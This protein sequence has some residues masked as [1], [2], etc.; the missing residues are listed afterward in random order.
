MIRLSQVLEI[1]ARYA[2][3]PRA[4]PDCIG[5]GYLCEHNSVYR[6]VRE[7]C[8]DLG[9]R[10]TA[11][12]TPLWR[13]YQVSSLLCLDGILRKKTIP[14]SDNAPLCRR[15]VSEVNAEFAV[16]PRLLLS[17]VRRNYV[18][19]ESAHCI[20]DS[21]LAARAAGGKQERVCR[22]LASEAFAN[23][24]EWL[25]WAH[26]DGPVHSLYFMFC[27]YVEHAKKRRDLLKN[28]VAE[29]GFDSI[30]EIALLSFLALNA[31]GKPLRCDD[32][33]EIV[34][35][36]LRRRAAPD[37]DVTRFA[38]AARDAFTLDLGFVNETSPAYFRLMQCEPE[39]LRV[40]GSFRGIESLQT[41]GLLE[42]ADRLKSVMCGPKGPVNVF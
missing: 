37:D 16:H 12:D 3:V 11:G 30:F 21:A 14:Y 8:T 39:F 13:D 35:P 41:I 42:A 36:V 1:D 26:T 19:H 29:L 10:Y 18:L 27:S 24:V 4:L 15:I 23:A 20:A 28:M 34:R 22:A 25:A 38:A 31:S 33:A 32:A 9:Y 7:M 2:G 5:D 6:R 40:L 17:I